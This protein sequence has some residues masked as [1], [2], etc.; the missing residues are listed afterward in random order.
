MIKLI[1][2][3]CPVELT[4]EIQEELTIEF[5]RTGED[6]W[7]DSRIKKPIKNALLMMS[8]NKCAYC[9]CKL[10]EGHY[11][12]AEHFIPKSTAKYR[13][14]AWENLLPAC[15]RCNGFKTS[16]TKE[17][18]NPCIDVPKEHLVLDLSAYFYRIYGKKGS[19]IGGVTTKYLGLNDF[20]LRRT[21]MNISEAA[22]E[23]CIEICSN[24][25]K[26]IDRSIFMKK[27][28][29]L[30]FKHKEAF[31]SLLSMCQED[32]A[33]SAVIAT[34]IFNCEIF[35]HTIDRM[36]SYN[37][38]CRSFDHPYNIILNNKFGIV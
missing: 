18:V 2:G 23:S 10:D 38:W 37:I 25:N 3:T 35:I 26:S 22:K 6:V 16:S 9:E 34:A 8:H 28:P 5:I 31:F 11:Y 7:N 1:R 13:V 20:K 24:I 19:K 36:K 27:I 33:Y 30:H 15:G 12:T 14:L 29:K 32:E 21:R 17:F 4:K